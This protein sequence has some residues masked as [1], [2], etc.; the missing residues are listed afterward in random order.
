MHRAQQLEHH[1]QDLRG[2]S[3]TT[4]SPNQVLMSGQNCSGLVIRGRRILFDSDDGYWLL[5]PSSARPT[6]TGGALRATW[7]SRQQL[8]SVRVASVALRERPLF[9]R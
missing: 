6:E 4:G 7:T 5:T 2:R 8:V 3:Y 9:G 1:F